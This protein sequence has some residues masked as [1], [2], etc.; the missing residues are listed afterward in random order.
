M[1]ADAELLANEHAIMRA[2]GRNDT[3]VL[4]GL[5]SP[6]VVFLTDQVGYIPGEDLFA[7]F[8]DLRVETFAIDQVHVMQAGNHSAIISYRLIQSG[9]FQG[10]PFSSQTYSTSIWRSD[11]GSWRVVFH[12]ET[13]IAAQGVAA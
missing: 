7:L 12:Q 4:R 9:H 5:M 13:P 6:D 11:A 10:A 2:L 3:A 8:S 1:I